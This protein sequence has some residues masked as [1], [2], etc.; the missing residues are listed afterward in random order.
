MTDAP[1]GSGGGI[2]TLVQL[3]GDIVTRATLASL[4]DRN[5]RER[6]QAQVQA[7]FAKLNRDW[8]RVRL[9]LNTAVVGASGSLAVRE[10][11]AFSL[12]S[13]GDVIW[14]VSP[15]LPLALRGGLGF[16]VRRAILQAVKSPKALLRAT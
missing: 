15:L 11:T 8:T 9:G 5:V 4:L 16:A 1:D 13:F 3:D 7:W 12:A 2:R 14:L 6:H 10:A